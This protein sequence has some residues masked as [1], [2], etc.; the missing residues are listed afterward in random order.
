MIRRERRGPDPT[1]PLGVRAR[2]AQFEESREAIARDA[3][4][5]E[6][7][8]QQALRDAAT[9]FEAGEIKR[10]IDA[11]ERNWPPPG[12]RDEQRPKCARCARRMELRPVFSSHAWTCHVPGH[13]ARQI[14]VRRLAAWVI[15][16]AQNLEAS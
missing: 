8:R 11:I 16:Q 12:L 7:D 13:P 9:L 6:R 15:K 5:A 1:R 4:E 2:V 14:D 3:A 10:A